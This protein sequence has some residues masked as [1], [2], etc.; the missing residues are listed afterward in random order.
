MK[1]VCIQEPIIYNKCYPPN[2]IINLLKS[3]DFIIFIYKL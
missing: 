3:N 1:I 2:K